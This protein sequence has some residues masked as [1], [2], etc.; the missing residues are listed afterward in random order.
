MTAAVLDEKPVILFRAL[1]KHLQPLLRPGSSSLRPRIQKQ[2]TNFSQLTTIILP[3]KYAKIYCV[4]Q[5]VG[6]LNVFSC[7]PLDSQSA[8]KL[9]QLQ[10]FCHLLRSQSAIIVRSNKLIFTFLEIFI[11]LL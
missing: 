7:V 8:N 5:L 9:M 2:D 6:A 3:V 10:T 11:C 1:I 4:D